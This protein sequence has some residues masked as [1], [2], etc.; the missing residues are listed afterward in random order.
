MQSLTEGQ[1][2][3]GAGVHCSV[4]TPR[5]SIGA[6]AVERLA[7]VKGDA[8]AGPIGRASAIT[9]LFSRTVLWA[10]DG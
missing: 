7:A 6:A 4:G 9:A 2:L 10:V 5:R 8:A 3:L 1:L